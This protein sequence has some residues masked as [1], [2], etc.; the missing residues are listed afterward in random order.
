LDKTA[1]T[2]TSPEEAYSIWK[3]K[4]VKGRTLLLFDHYP[5]AQGLS[6]YKG[7]PQLT[8]ANLIEFSIFKNIIRKIYF[9]V[10]DE[11]WEDF[12]QQELMR[13]IRPTPG[14]ERGLYLW[15]YSGIDLIAVT[16]TS[17]PQL[18]EEP[19]VYIN[20]RIYGEAQTREFLSMKNIESDIMILY[21]GGGK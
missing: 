19:L 15:T 16:P 13:P 14:L 10:P 20:D 3:D 1:H 17:L 6:D 5:H 4:N 12:R 7:A 2:I 18:T 21:K 11:M 8:N 9:I